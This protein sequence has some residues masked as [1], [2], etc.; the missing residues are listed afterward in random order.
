[1]SQEQF[2][3]KVR[4]TGTSMGINIPPEIIQLLGIN[5]NDI[6]RVI[7]EKVKK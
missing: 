1:M 4:K 5:E 7:V 2:V 3:R 6:V